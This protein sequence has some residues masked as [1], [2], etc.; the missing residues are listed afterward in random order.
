M[1]TV[2]SSL[3]ATLDP[4]WPARTA[5]SRYVTSRM[6]LQAA[7][8]GRGLRGRTETMRK[9]WPARLFSAGP[10]IRSVSA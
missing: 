8:A 9:A 7:M 1:T 3:M 4:H 5:P 2:I 10:E 6:G